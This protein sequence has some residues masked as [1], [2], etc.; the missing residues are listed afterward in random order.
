MKLAFISSI[1]AFAAV[2]NAQIQFTQPVQGVVWTA[3]QMATIQWQGKD[4]ASLNDNLLTIELLWGPANGVISLGN[5]AIIKGSAGTANVLVSKDLITGNQYSVRANRTSYSDT[6]EIDN[7]N[8]PN[9]S[10]NPATVRLPT[11]T[12]STA[13]RLVNGFVA[14]G[15]ALGAM[16]LL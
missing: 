2:V 1:L 5:L 13:S 12:P 8:H 7:S 3:G 10:G 11:V 16:A 4:G 9:G 14:M 6:F 15:A